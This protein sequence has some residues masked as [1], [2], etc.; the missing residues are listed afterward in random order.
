MGDSGVTMRAWVLD[1]IAC[2]SCAGRLA[3]MP[4]RALLVACRRCGARFPVLGGVPIVVP[5]PADYLAGYRDAAL[6]ALAERGR[7]PRV[8]V[9]VVDAFAR[10]GA[11]T[12]PLAFGDD[13]VAHEVGDAAPPAGDAAAM[14]DAGPAAATFRR[15][16]DATGGDASVDAAIIAALPARP[17]TIVEVGAG[18]GVLA[19]R[20]ARVPGVER[21]VVGD[22]SLRAAL[23]AAGRGPRVAAAVLDAEALPLRPRSVDAIVAAELV[24]LLAAPERLLE[25]AAVALRPRGRLILATPD[26]SLGTGDDDRLLALLARDRWRVVAHHRRVPWV[27]P[28][29]PRHYQV[30]FADVLAAER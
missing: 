3:V 20:L 19:R 15:F 5:S 7:A 22:L 27:R 10:A 26:P 28:H 14:A 6:A 11:R 21:L 12:E 18:A 4:G 29:T 9:A 23:R 17:R 24:D 13:W 30:Y 1:V 25:A 2:A 16:L 8:A